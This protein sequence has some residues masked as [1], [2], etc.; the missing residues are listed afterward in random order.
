MKDVPK[1]LDPSLQTGRY[2]V[3]ILENPELTY[4]LIQP[5]AGVSSPAVIG[6]EIEAEF[7]TDE[8]LE[9]DVIQAPKVLNPAID[10][11]GLHRVMISN[12]NL[13]FHVNLGAA[14]FGYGDTSSFQI[15]DQGKF[16]ATSRRICC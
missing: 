14:G 5:G 13:V 3:E 4:K 9:T 16:T 1:V 10:G 12:S 8:A 15:K 2:E 6:I 11:E 7:L